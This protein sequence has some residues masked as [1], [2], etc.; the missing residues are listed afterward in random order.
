VAPVVGNT[1]VWNGVAW[2]PATPGVTPFTLTAS[3]NIP[4][5]ALVSVN[6][7][8]EAQLANTS[9]ALTPRRYEVIGVAQAAAL[10]AAGARV[11]TTKT[12]TIKG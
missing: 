12:T 10:A 7:S 3:V 2:T 8:G 1:L 4:L 11:T 9:T 5:G 6:A